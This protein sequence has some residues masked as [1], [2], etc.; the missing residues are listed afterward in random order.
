MKGHIASPTKMGLTWSS[1]AY[2]PWRC[3]HLVGKKHA[4]EGLTIHKIKRIEEV[5]IH[6]GINNTLTLNH[7]DLHVHQPL[8]EVI[9]ILEDFI[10]DNIYVAVNNLYQDPPKICM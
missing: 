4:A 8:N 7:Q 6:Y 5:W 2:E 10:R 9:I 3:P 1:K